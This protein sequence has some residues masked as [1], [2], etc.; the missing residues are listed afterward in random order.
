MTRQEKIKEIK[1]T[2]ETKLQTI[3]RMTKNLKR[4]DDFEDILTIIKFY[5]WLNSR[6][7][8]FEKKVSKI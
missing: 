5:S 8:T 4:P 1:K 3:E 6:I 7:Y 2:F